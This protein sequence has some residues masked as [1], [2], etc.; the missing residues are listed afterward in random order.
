M[1]KVLQIFFLLFLLGSCLKEPEFNSYQVKFVIDFGADFPEEH[2]A[3]AK[4]YL[5]N[6]LKNY[7]V[8]AVTNPDGSIQF[9]SVEPGFYSIT[10]SHSFISGGVVYAYNGAENVEIFGNRT[11]SVKVSGTSSSAFVIKEFYFSG[12]TTPA[13]KSYSADQ[14]I[15]IFN[16]SPEVQFADGLSVLEHESYGTGENYWAN[17][18]DTIVVKMIWTIPGDGQQIPVLPGKSIVL[19]R[20]AIN[21]RDDPKGNPLSPVNLANADFEFY[22]AKQPE[23]D[24]DS[25]TVPNLIEDLF[26]FRGNDVAFHVKG[27]SAIAIAKIPGKT[28]QERKT[29]MNNNLVAKASA[30]GSGNTFYVKIANK[31]VFDAVE[32]VMD[33]AHAIYKRF[34]SELDAG[35][36]FITSGSYSGKCIRRKIKEITNGRVVYQDTNNSNEDFLQDADPK[37]KIYE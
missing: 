34:P 6:Q 33:E 14:Y 36:I 26:V 7:T 9:E 23:T 3:G 29:Y 15:E 1:N 28:S 2:K 18:S 13:G 32:V 37:P 17:I 25:P 35:Y 10:V 21:H 4:V 22:V 31:Y 5:F 19:A 8:E 27:G 20:T 12:S 30:S 11:E 24:I 16:N